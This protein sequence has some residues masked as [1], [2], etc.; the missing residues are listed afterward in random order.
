MN[1]EFTDEAADN[2]RMTRGGRRVWIAIAISAAL[3][4]SA[5][6][7]FSIRQG[8]LVSSHNTID[9][10]EELPVG[11][12]VHLLGK[13]TYVDAPGVGLWI[14]DQ[15]GVLVI[16]LS[17]SNVRVDEVVTVDAAKASPYDPIRGPGSL[18][19]SNLSIHLSS[20]HL[21]VPQP[22]PASLATFPGP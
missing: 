17:S 16:P 22:L 7:G 19:L 13:V 2:T 20:I 9:E 18:L 21:K 4:V 3:I 1:V 11:A 14:Q 5:A 12:S 6:L 8:L 15:T 10:L